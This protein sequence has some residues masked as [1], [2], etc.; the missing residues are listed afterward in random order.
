MSDFWTKSGILLARF[1]LAFLP[2]REEVE[3]EETHPGLCKVKAEGSY[4]MQLK[5]ELVLGSDQKI[6]YAYTGEARK[7]PRMTQK[8]HSEMAKLLTSQ[9]SKPKLREKERGGRGW[10][11][12]FSRIYFSGNNCF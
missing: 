2:P 9:P 8:S 3:T 10:D 12:H 11:F 7:P 1:P 6:M 4:F 5:A